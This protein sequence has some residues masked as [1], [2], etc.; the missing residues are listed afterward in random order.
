VS[1]LSMHGQPCAPS[2]PL[3]WLHQRI[4]CDTLP[5]HRVPRRDVAIITLLEAL[6]NA[7]YAWAKEPR[8]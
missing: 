6:E 5:G 3:F 2:E 4:L 7:T 8:Q 1:A